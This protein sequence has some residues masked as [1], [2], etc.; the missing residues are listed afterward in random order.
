MNCCN[1]KARWGRFLFLWQ[2]Q[3]AN[4]AWRHVNMTAGQ[5][6][7]FAGAMLEHATAGRISAAQHRVVRL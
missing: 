7:V 4:G 1:K 5:V 6:A 3:D 2:V